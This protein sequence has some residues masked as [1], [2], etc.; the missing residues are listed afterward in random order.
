MTNLLR[1]LQVFALGTWVGAIIYLSFVVAPGVFGTLANRDQAG[2]V[3]GLV[4]GRLHVL[5]LIAA[6]VYLGAAICLW[7]IYSTK[8]LATPAVAM[9]IVMAVLTLISQRAVTPRMAELRREMVSVDATPRDNPLR[10]KFDELHRVS[11]QLEGAAL[12]IG[13][14]AL[15]LTIRMAAR[16]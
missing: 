8:E 4:L 11:V 7:M 5:G 14:G 10:V 6:A 3:V 1:F 12:V 2:A 13:I 9:V 16:H 15:Y